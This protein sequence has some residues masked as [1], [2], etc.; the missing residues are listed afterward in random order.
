MKKAFRLK[1]TGTNEINKWALLLKYWFL[2][3]WE[4]VS[5]PCCYSCKLWGNLLWYSSVIHHY[6]DRTR[7]SYNGQLH[8]SMETRA[9]HTSYCGH[10][11]S[12]DMQIFKINQDMLR[13][14]SGFSTALFNLKELI[15]LNA[16]QI[17]SRPK[18]L[19]HAKLCSIEWHLFQESR[20]N[21]SQILNSI[22]HA[23]SE[24]V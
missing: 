7:D 15:N 23:S 1:E 9:W 14:A 6:F 20:S 3:I 8:S 4:K 2:F 24:K 22:F 13:L 19:P 12:C 18:K 16:V 17:S 5:K 10:F 11:K 21:Y